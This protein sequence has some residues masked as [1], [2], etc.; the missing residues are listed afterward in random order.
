MEIDTHLSNS[1]ITFAFVS[2]TDVAGGPLENVFIR[3]VN[4]HQEAD[5]VLPNVSPIDP[6][7][8]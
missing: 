8:T 5:M 2:A 6:C 4:G 7:H 1:G 3:Y